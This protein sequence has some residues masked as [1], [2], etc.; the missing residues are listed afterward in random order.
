MQTITPT[1]QQRVLV[2]N[3][4]DLEGVECTQHEI[5]A[6]VE[7]AFRALGRRA[8]DN[9]VKTIVQPRDKR[10]IAY[11]MTGRDGET[12]TIGFK[13]AYEFDP[14]RQRHQYQNHSLMF[15]CDDQ[16]GRPLALMD[17]ITID[18]LRTAATTALLARVAAAEHAR[19]ALLVGTGLVAR[20]VLPLLTEA[21]PQ[22]ERLLVYG[23]HAAGVEAVCEGARRL[24]AGRAIEAARDLEHAARA[25]DIVIGATGAGA[26]HAVRQGWLRPG[27]TSVLLGYGIAADVLHGA[28]YRIATDRAQMKVTGTDLALADG[29]LPE[30]DAELPAI[31]LGEQVG[32]QH[33]DQRVFAYNSGMVVTDIAL[34]R[35]L[36]ERARLHGRGLEVRLW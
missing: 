17:V 21:I 33:Q 35:L 24:C 18:A 22:L 1:T 5:L 15:L 14:Q 30:V 20:R 27:A 23:R 8:S 4:A 32:R 10:S 26:T 29:S 19:T 34:G 25:A 31:V 2:L 28:D 36:V 6:V 7:R 12:E 3:Q 11:S 13:L 16:S 9:P